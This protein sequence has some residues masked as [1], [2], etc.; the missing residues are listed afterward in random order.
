MRILWDTVA[1]ELS[2]LGIAAQ[3]DAERETITCA[4]V[5]LSHGE[6]MEAA[7]DQEAT[8]PPSIARMIDDALKEG[9]FG[10]YGSEDR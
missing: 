10:P 5:T 2:K 1:E 7:N 9:N 8:D 3:N 6:V 4:G